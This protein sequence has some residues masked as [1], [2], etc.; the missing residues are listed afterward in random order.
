MSDNSCSQ[1][2]NDSVD[3]LA[4]FAQSIIKSLVLLVVITCAYY[5]KSKYLPKDGQEPI[6]INMVL[7]ILLGTVLL[8]ILGVTDM[9]IFN[10]V[11]L[12]LGIGFGIRL[13]DL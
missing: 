11:M 7:F 3:R 1:K 10:N 13:F 12:G 8:T 2:D 5:L 9:Y 4:N 6:M